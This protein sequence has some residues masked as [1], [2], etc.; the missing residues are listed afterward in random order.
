M[1]WHLLCDALFTWEDEAEALM[2][3]RCFYSLLGYGCSSSCRCMQE[4]DGPDA[5][6]LL[7]LAGSRPGSQQRSSS[8]SRP[9]LWAVGCHLFKRL[10][11][12]LFIWDTAGKATLFRD[13]SLQ[14]DLECPRDLTH[15]PAVLYLII[16]SVLSFSVQ[17][18]GA[19]GIVIVLATWVDVL[20]HVSF[21]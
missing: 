9:R 8:E 11:K 12:N 7:C 15:L 13:P 10:L 3:V 21:V 17:P 19:S 18:H 16:S 2:T 20:W 1:A 14:L 5:Y 6:A 4:P